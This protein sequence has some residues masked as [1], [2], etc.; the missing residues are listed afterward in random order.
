MYHT[1][2]GIE[3]AVKQFL[4]NKPWIKEDVRS[5]GLQTDNASNYRD[6]IHI[7]DTPALGAAVFSAIP[8]GT[9]G[10]TRDAGACFSW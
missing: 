10:G 6:P 4:S 7:I 2:G 8:T 5:N 1:K 9:R 3:C